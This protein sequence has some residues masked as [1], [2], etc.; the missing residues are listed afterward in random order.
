M[1]ILI[2]IITVFS[3]ILSCQERPSLQGGATGT[4]VMHQTVESRADQIVIS[5]FDGARGYSCA[6][7][8]GMAV[9]SDHLVQSSFSVHARS[10]RVDNIPIGLNRVFLFQVWGGSADGGADMEIARGCREGVT[11]E[12]GIITSL[13]PIELHPLST[14]FRFTQSPS[15]GTVGS[16]VLLVGHGFTNIPECQSVRFTG[17]LPDGGIIWREAPVLDALPNQLRVSVPPGALTGPILVQVKSGLL[18]GGINCP[19]LTLDGGWRSTLSEGSYS[20]KPKIDEIIYQDEGNSS[21]QTGQVVTIMGS[22]FSPVVKDNFVQ[23]PNIASLAP[24]TAGHVRPD[25][26]VPQDLSR[27][28]VPTGLTSGRLSLSVGVGDELSSPATFKLNPTIKEISPG[29]APDN[30]ILT[31]YG[32]G[33]GQRVSSILVRFPS[34]IEPGSFIETFPTKVDGKAMTVLVPSTADTGQVTLVVSELTSNPADWL[35]ANVEDPQS[36]PLPQEMTPD[37]SDLLDI[38]ISGDNS[39]LFIVNR[40]KAMAVAYKLETRQMGP[41]HKL[42]DHFNDVRPIPNTVHALKPVLSHDQRSIYIMAYGDSLLPNKPSGFAHLFQL[43]QTGALQYRPVAAAELFRKVSPFSS[44]AITHSNYLLAAIDDETIATQEHDDVAVL[45]LEA[46]DKIKVHYLSDLCSR[47]DADRDGGLT[48]PK[49]WNISGIYSDTHSPVAVIVN[50]A[51]TG[52]ATVGSGNVRGLIPHHV[53]FVLLERGAQGPSC[54]KKWMDVNIS[55]TANVAFNKDHILITDAGQKKVVDLNPS[56][57]SFKDGE[58]LQM[59][60]RLLEGDVPE[61]VTRLLPSPSGKYLFAFATPLEIVEAIG[62]GQWQAAGNNLHFWSLPC[63]PVTQFNLEDFVDNFRPGNNKYDLRVLELGAAGQALPIPTATIE[64][65]GNFNPAMAHFAADE[66]TLYLMTDAN[67]TGSATPRDPALLHIDLQRFLDENAGIGSGVSKLNLQSGDSS[68]DQYTPAATTLSRDGSQ[69]MMV[70]RAS[71][72]VRPFI[73]RRKR[74]FEVVGSEGYAYDMALSAGNEGHVLFLVPGENESVHLIAL[75]TRTWLNAGHANLTQ[76]THTRDPHFL[77]VG[78]NYAIIA[79]T[80][81]TSDGVGRDDVCIIKTGDWSGNLDCVTVPGVPASDRALIVE[82]GLAQGAYIKTVHG[83]RV[84]FVPDIGNPAGQPVAEYQL[85]VRLSEIISTDNGQSFIGLYNSLTGFGPELS[86]IYKLDKVETPQK[87]F[88][89]AQQWTLDGSPGLPIWSPLGQ[90]LLIPLADSPFINL[91][92]KGEDG[93]WDIS[94]LFTFGGIHLGGVFSPVPDPTP[95][96]P[97]LKAYLFDVLGDALTTMAFDNKQQDALPAYAAPS[98]VIAIDR[99]DQGFTNAD[100][101]FRH[102]SLKW[103]FSPMVLTHDGAFLWVNTGESNFLTV[104]D[105]ATGLIRA[106]V[107]LKRSDPQFRQ[108]LVFKNAAGTWV[109]ARDANSGQLHFIDAGILDGE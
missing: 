76:I 108:L 32:E 88:E 52:T 25:G 34:A 1:R 64:G 65:L 90:I 86:Y 26:G 27:F 12:S 62:G 30:G 107:P 84:H 16:E 56:P 82:N 43:W 11:I 61:N 24:V 109:I 37:S 85:S 35:K 7:T 54:G 47:S 97:L 28:I 81:R 103:G 74:P 77:A 13:G 42:L 46:A 93:K 91:M 45:D 101:Q 49:F 99:S 48:K 59:E 78:G 58:P 39:T 66:R 21:A 23:L 5:V 69:L 29:F 75:S 41:V 53:N 2:P 31:I 67:G 38:L 98:D 106:R 10:A 104:I 63:I 17:K 79:N 33:L 94:R 89:V 15:S 92:G 105:L 20:V 6:A 3:L 50:T 83:D 8:G 71:W 55:T 95:G 9:S 72:K 14:E 87:R 96:E 70:D 80:K 68:S 40:G 100:Y 18:D 36:I 102:M 60:C 73:E 22:G 44:I 4:L 19:S 51:M 57:D